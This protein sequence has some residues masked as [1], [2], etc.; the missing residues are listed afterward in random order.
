MPRPR[1]FLLLAAALVV[2][3]QA[4]K[5]AAVAWLV[6]GRP[7][8]VVPSVN[9]LL[10]YNPGISFSFLALPGGAQRWPLAALALVISALLVRWLWR[11]PRGRNVLGVGIAFVLGGAL[12]NLVD[13]VA[14]GRVTDFVQLYVGSWSFAIFNL[15]DAALSLGVVLVL[16]DRLLPG[17]AKAG[18]PAS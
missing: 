3:D 4:A 14:A 13:R 10:T 16:V 5:H 17:A 18:A 8:P 12:G 11:L 6:P 2:L 15:A 9:L 1:R 7:F